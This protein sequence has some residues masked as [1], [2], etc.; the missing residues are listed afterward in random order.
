MHS[1]ATNKGHT[2][3]CYYNFTMTGGHA[4]KVFCT[5]EMRD[6]FNRYDETYMDG[7]YCIDAPQF[8]PTGS[9]ANQF[10]PY[11]DNFYEVVMCTSRHA[12]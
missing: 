5:I 12:T 8:I 10:D 3:K 2:M 11:A 6:S 9:T 7:A 1:I 4:S